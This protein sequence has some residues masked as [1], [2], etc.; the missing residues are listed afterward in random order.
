VESSSWDS[1]KRGYSVSC[2]LVFL[3]L[4]KAADAVSAEGKR[5]LT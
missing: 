3:V 4:A 5:S 2:D 1:R